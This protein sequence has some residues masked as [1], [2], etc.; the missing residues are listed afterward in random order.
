MSESE[1][2]TAQK[3]FW[4]LV[5]GAVMMVASLIATLLPFV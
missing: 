4:L 2:K 5:T 1:L 3:V